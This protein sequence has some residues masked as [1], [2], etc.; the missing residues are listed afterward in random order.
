LNK[1]LNTPTKLLLRILL[2]KECYFK[3]IIYVIVLEF[4]LEYSGK[5]FHFYIYI[6]AQQKRRRN[7]FF[8]YAITNNKSH[9]V[10]NFN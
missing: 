7:K 8:I 4:Y 5:E 10:E 2:Q 1:D 6:I 3:K 9:E